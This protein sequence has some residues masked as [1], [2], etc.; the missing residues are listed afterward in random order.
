MKLRV[1]T[2]LLLSLASL[3]VVLTAANYAVQK[4]V[5][6]KR[7]AKLEEDAARDD[8]RRCR[9][10]IRRELELN[11]LMTRDWATWDDPYKYMVDRNKEFEVS[12]FTDEA[13]KTSGFHVLYFVTNEGEI[14]WGQA[15]DPQL[16]PTTLDEF[17]SDRF[18]AEHEWLTHK[19]PLDGDPQISGILP[20][21]HGPMLF[22]ARPI[23]TSQKTGPARG[24][25]IMGRYL[26]P[27][28]V[29]ALRAQTRVHF[30]IHQ[31]RGAETPSRATAALARLRSAD[32]LMLQ[33]RDAD[34]TLGFA[35]MGD[36]RGRPALVIEAEIPRAISAQGHITTHVMLM[37]MVMA[38]V[39]TAVLLFFAVRFVVV[40]PLEWLT[41]E[42]RKIGQTADLTVRLGLKRNDELGTLAGVFDEM[43]ARLAEARATLLETS[44][45]AGMADVATGVLH[46][47]GNVLN[48]VNVST[49]TL[50]DNVKKS[51]VGGLARAVA[52]L[53]SNRANMAEFI[54][55]DERGRNLP[56]YLSQLA[57]ALAD[58]QRSV[59]TELG[60][61]KTSVDHV[62]QIVQS[63]HAFARKV[64]HVEPTNLRELVSNALAIM[65]AA[66]KRHGIALQSDLS[67]LPT[68]Q[69]DSAKCMQVLVNLLTNAKEALGALGKG[70]KQ[71]NV[72]LRVVNENEA[73]IEVA[74]NGVGISRDNLT[75]I[76][77]NGFTT[78]PSGRGFGL[79]Y[80]ALAATEMGGQLT[81]HSDGPG[82]GA[83]FMLRLPLRLVQE[84]NV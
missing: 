23:L 48:S 19:L 77:G 14:V 72:R 81:V 3:F 58:E 29:E 83:C 51:K 31:V 30:E 24:T 12:N 65:E 52:L 37:F 2:K 16:A 66:F 25:L 46:N 61:L 38:A 13:W 69:L 67:Q 73:I 41:E 57:Q 50:V 5:V 22:C 17:P 1:D 27:A 34:H 44:R 32:D 39:L 78:K 47:V 33:Q 64:G 21:R 59:L 80:C 15:R 35:F 6:M 53:E 7:F 54:T 79:H 28:K 26:S 4:S 55:R 10:A 18:P 49:T 74:D 68:V 63:Q 70:D 62:N 45:D 82:C 11:S 36:P 20:T 76:F 42:A 40:K 60:T 8:L 43:V 9:D 56:T 71:L 75:R 84:A